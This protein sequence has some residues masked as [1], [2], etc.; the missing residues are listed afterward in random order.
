MVSSSRKTAGERYWNREAT[1]MLKLT[2]T[3]FCH[4][5]PIRSRTHRSNTASH[6]AW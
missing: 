1:T 4:A 2:P 5:F 3:S 6:S